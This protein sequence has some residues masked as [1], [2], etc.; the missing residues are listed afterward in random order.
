MASSVF[1]RFQPGLRAAYAAEAVTGVK[2]AVQAPD[3]VV[4]T[5][6]EDV[7]EVDD[8]DLVLLLLT[9]VDKV[10]AVVDV[11]VLDT[12]ELELET[13]VLEDELL[14]AVPGTHWE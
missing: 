9:L 14:L 13:L 7:L 1:P 4:E 11:L 10:V 2:A 6:T 5:A 3:A 8:E 12:E